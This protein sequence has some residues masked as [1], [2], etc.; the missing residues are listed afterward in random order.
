MVRIDHLIEPG[1]PY[2]SRQLVEIGQARSRQRDDR[3]DTRGV[4]HQVGIGGFG[5]QGHLVVTIT[6]VVPG[7]FGQGPAQ[8]TEI[9]QRAETD[10]QDTRQLVPFGGNGSRLGR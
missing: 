3:F 2:D 9:P 1:R 5:H 6:I 8:E 4:A 7:E 10:D